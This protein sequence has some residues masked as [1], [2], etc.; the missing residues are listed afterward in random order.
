MNLYI[1]NYYKLS[2]LS[3]IYTSQN[4]TKILTFL[5]IYVFIKSKNYI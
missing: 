5:Y 3:N 4:V 1:Y 2:G